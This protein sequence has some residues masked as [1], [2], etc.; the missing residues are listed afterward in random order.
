MENNRL[1]IKNNGKYLDL[2]FISINFVEN[3]VN[4]LGAVIAG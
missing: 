2:S 3:F 4:L 1:Y